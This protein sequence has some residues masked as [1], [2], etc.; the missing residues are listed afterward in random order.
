MRS[1]VLL[2]CAPLL[3]A[4]QLQFTTLPSTGPSPRFDGTI[5]YDPAANQI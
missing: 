2:L 3:F 5:A 4:Q 1:L